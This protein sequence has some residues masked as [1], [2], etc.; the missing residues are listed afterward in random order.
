MASPVG[1]GD[2]PASTAG[3]RSLRPCCTESSTA[4]NSSNGS[5]WG[6]CALHL[7]SE[8]DDSTAWPN[9]YHGRVVSPKHHARPWS[10]PHLVRPMTR[11]LHGHTPREQFWTPFTPPRWSIF[12]A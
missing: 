10:S 8:T 3:K 12:H 4:V 11:H 2:H 1:I 9:K 5:K 7:I 6:G